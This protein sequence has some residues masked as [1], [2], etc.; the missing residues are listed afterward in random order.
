MGKKIERWI[1]L[2]GLPRFKDGTY[3]G[4]INWKE[5]VGRSI[6]FKYKDIIGEVFVSDYDNCYLTVLYNNNSHKIHCTNFINCCLGRL[7]NEITPCFKRHAGQIVNGVNI[8]DT[9]IEKDKNGKK[10][11]YY[12]YKCSVCGFDCGENYVRGKLRQEHKIT[13]SALTR[14]TG[15]ACCS[16]TITVSHINSIVANEET[17]WM[18]NYFQGDTYEEKYNLAKRYA[19]QSG[20]DMYFVCPDC[21]TTKH[22]KIVN[23][24]KL[25]SISCAC[26]GDGYSY[27]EKVMYNILMQLNI[28]FETQYSPDYLDKKRSDFYIPNLNL[29]IETDGKLGHMGGKVHTKS[30][31][32]IEECIAIDNWKDEQHLK[33]GV[34]TIRIDCFESDMEY[35]KTNILNSELSNYFDFGS[36]DWNKVNEYALKS[37]LKKEVCDHWNN[38]EEWETT[39]S[40]SKIFKVA[41][42][43]I[44]EYLKKGNEL[45]WCIYDAN[46]E[47]RKV[48]FPSK[49]VQI[50]KN[51]EMIGAFNSV[52]EL[53]RQSEKLF[54][55]K[56]DNRKIS[57]VARG[58]KPQ[59]KGFTFR[60]IT[61]PTNQSCQQ[62]SQD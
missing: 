21:G 25:K 60:Y 12:K 35:I 6:K 41:S 11:K 51:S 22:T 38:K 44:R 33:H 59:Y 43:T 9:T 56:L 19:P 7:L 23:L 42:K 26:C 39:E 45:G 47:S 10:Y 14:G 37:N 58:L 18:V 16:N 27:P 54:G 32:S 36:I 61:E 5:V 29:V 4:K 48:K 17:M 30:N 57:M 62:Q 3:V 13:E 55:V 20:Q 15:C 49:M 8:T 1:D 24:Y 2:S 31:K 40:M 34:K 28:G 52:Y 53:E 50:F 46:V